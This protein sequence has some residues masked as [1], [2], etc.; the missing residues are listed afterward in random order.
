MTVT[1][2]ASPGLDSLR[3]Q[4]Y[5]VT[6]AAV[7]G[8]QT[9]GFVYGQSFTAQ[10]ENEVWDIGQEVQCDWITIGADEPADVRITLIDG[11]IFSAKVYPAD[12]GVTQ[13]IVDGQL[14]VV[15]PSNRRLRIEVNGDRR[16]PL[17][18]FVSLP[19]AA[20]PVGSSAYVAQTS[21]AA[22]AALHFPPG[23]HLVSA[24]FV[25]G[26]NCT[27]TAQGGAVVIFTDPDVTGT[28]AS[29]TASSITVSGTPWV[30]G[31]YNTLEVRISG[32]TGAGQVRTITT[33]TTNTLNVTPN[34]T[35]NP[36]AGSTFTILSARRAG[37]D[38]STLTSANTAGVTIQG[39]GV[40]TSLAQRANAEQVLSFANQVRYCPIATDTVNTSP[41]NC[42]VIGPTFVRWPFYFQ[43]GGA[44]YL[45]NVQWLNP[46]VFN[47][48]GFQPGRKSLSDNAGLVIDSYTYCADDG[49]KAFVPLHRI[50]FHN[51]F[52]V[53]ARASC[54]KIGYFGNT[55]NDSTGAQII[56]C[57]AMN[58]GDS[59]DA[60]PTAGSQCIV[61]AFVDKPNA[62]AGDG[63]YNISVTG[64]RVWGRMYNRLFCFQNLPYPFAG[65]TP[66]DGAGQIFDVSFSDVATEFA[67]GQVSLILGRDSISTPHDMTFANVVLGGT[68]LDADNFDEFVTVNQFPYNLTW[69]AP[70][71]VAET[72][73]GLS[74]ATSYC[75]I[76]FANA[77]LTNYGTPAAWTAATNA[78]KETALMAATRAL[79]VRYGGRWVG[80]RYSTTQALDWPRDYAY[81]AAGELIASDVVPLRVQQATAVLAALHV[82]GVT[83]NPTTRT[84]GDIKS[85]SLSSAS[86]SSKSVTYAGT[87][88]AET[89]LVE[90]ERMLATAGL[91]SGS[92]SWGWM[93]L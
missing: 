58:L 56:D 60:Y 73:S 31:A 11:P 6:A 77:Y 27:V 49:C 18:L 5:L 45:R 17:N 91:I 54:W 19:Q 90:A 28:A 40:F 44:H 9:S 93:D 74:T 39:H 85:E 41:V 64:L 66:A 20:L 50:T 84:T 16:S 22:G 37:F 33:S 10:G 34:W 68:T 62:F 92:S 1:I 89:Q 36:T 83:I 46:W 29:A 57:D 21:V 42:R 59:D 55:V 65:V 32:G 71:L 86:G 25:L 75:T 79:D 3:S 26:D 15:V 8:A 82:Q 30:V 69:D 14:R 2:Y 4:K 87:K 12:V 67:P 76:A 53:A 70:G 61:A 78:T 38:L 48:D 72:G 43:Y 23:V 47:S 24:G 35:T 81:D 80:Y 51:V 63:Y 13:T 52:V 88:P 7:S